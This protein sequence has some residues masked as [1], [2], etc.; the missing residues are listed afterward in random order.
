[1]NRI[2][3]VV[4]IQ[5]DTFGN[6]LERGAIQVD[7]GASHAQKSAGIRQVLQP[8][9]SRLRTQFAV[10]GNE[11]MR[12]FEYR[13][14]AKTVGVVAVLVAGGDHQE[15]EPDDVGESVR[16]LVRCPR[17]LDAAS[18][19]ISDAQSLLDLAQHQDAAVR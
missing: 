15:A 13:I 10:R 14:D 7:H 17:I 16:N 4:D 12:H 5:H 3:R 9:D 18:E 11:V 6:V 1:V 8:R 19:T 2:E